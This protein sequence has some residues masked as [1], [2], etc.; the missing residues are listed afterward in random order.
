[1]GSNTLVGILS[2]IAC[3]Y[4]ITTYTKRHGNEIGFYV[5][6]YF[7]MFPHKLSAIS[8]LF[9]DDI[10]LKAFLVF[11]FIILIWQGRRIRV[12]WNDIAILFSILL[13]DIIAWYKSLYFENSLIITGITNIFFIVFFIILFRN[14]VKTVQGMNV[15]WGILLD[16]A[17]FLS[18]GAIIEALLGLASRSELGLGNPNYLAFYIAFASCILI[19]KTQKVKINTLIR[20]ILYFLG[21]LCTGSTS[22]LICLPAFLL[23]KLVYSIVGDHAS[24]LITQIICIASTACI[25]LIIGLTLSPA[26]IENELMQKILIG[27]DLERISIW[28]NAI[29]VWKSNAIFGTG[30]NCWRTSFGIGYVTHNDFLRIFVETGIFGV[31]I[32]SVYW[33]TS[34]KQIIES[35]RVNHPFFLSLIILTVMF[36]SFHNNI[37]SLMFWLVLSIPWYDNVVELR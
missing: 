15:I 20:A 13:V 19:Y 34:L 27:K 25:F 14:R 21:I 30:Y 29:E 33:V 31:A 26:V 4:F 1:M 32:F 22:I 24:K 6:I 16:N 23:L 17:A 12:N 10:A 35:K 9:F 8:Y 18:I 37:N 28:K 36:S 2:T 5:Y 3:I 11:D 7:A